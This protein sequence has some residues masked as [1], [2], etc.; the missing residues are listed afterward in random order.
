MFNIS[1]CYPQLK[2]VTTLKQSFL[3]TLGV[4][5]GMGCKCHVSAACEIQCVEDLVRGMIIM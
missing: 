4:A 2:L 5:C 3:L 1:I